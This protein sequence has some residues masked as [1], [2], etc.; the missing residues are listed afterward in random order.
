MTNSTLRATLFAGSLMLLIGCGAGG[1]DASEP[2]PDSEGDGSEAAND[3]A[4]SSDGTGQA[5]ESP[6][7]IARADIS[8]RGLDQDEKKLY[9]AGPPLADTD[10]NYYGPDGDLIWSID[11]AGGHPKPLFNN[12]AG[13]VADVAVDR[14]KV[15]FSVGGALELSASGDMASSTYRKGQIMRVVASGGPAKVVAKNQVEPK[16]VAADGG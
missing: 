1:P 13:P 15:L 12:P 6:S 4:T 8:G 9:F 16:S 5:L 7:T 11:K 14:G 2:R 10:G 3:G